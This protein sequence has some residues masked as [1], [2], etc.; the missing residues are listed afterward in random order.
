MRRPHEGRWSSSPKLQEKSWQYVVILE[1]HCTDSSYSSVMNIAAL[2]CGRRLVPT[3]LGFSQKKSLPP[4]ENISQI[5]FY[6]KILTNHLAFNSE[7]PNLWNSYQIWGKITL[8][9]H[10]ITHQSLFQPYDWRPHNLVI[11]EPDY[12]ARGCEFGPRY[13]QKFVWWI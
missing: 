4:V 13:G 9:L 8:S 3:Q 11:S 7:L 1:T 6:Y 2:L 10:N 5:H 12:D